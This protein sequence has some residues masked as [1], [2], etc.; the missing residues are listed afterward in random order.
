MNRFVESMESLR[1]ELSGD[2]DNLRRLAEAIPQ[3]LER[4]ERQLDRLTEVAGSMEQEDTEIE[5]LISRYAESRPSRGRGARRRG[6]TLPTDIMALLHA[7]G[8]NGASLDDL[9]EGLTKT[10]HVSK[11]NLSST[12]SRMKSHGKIGKE[13]GMFIPNE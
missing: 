10:R 11:Q 7:A 6:R 9:F 2:I 4:K 12:L 13:D 5:S 1:R 8:P 3:L